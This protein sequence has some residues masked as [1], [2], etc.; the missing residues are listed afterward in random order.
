VLG[1]CDYFRSFPHNVTF[2]CHLEGEAA[3]I[4][5]FRSRHATAARLDG[6]S[7][8]DMATPEDCLSPAVCYHVYHMYQGRTLTGP[9][10]T[11]GVCGRCF[12]FESANITDLRRL[13][14]F[15]MREIVFLGSR[16]R[17][18]AERDAAI[19]RFSESRRSPE[20]RTASAPSSS[21]QMPSPKRIPVERGDKARGP[22]LWPA[23]ATAAGR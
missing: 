6:R 23:A 22:L 8:Q 19:E 11:H 7:L 5:G 14:E 18:L 21:R 12:R 20:I 15:T 4:E 13:W 16:N 9:L 2:A 1:R 3:V 17:V 10:H